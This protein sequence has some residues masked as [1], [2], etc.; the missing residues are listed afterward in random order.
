MT[1]KDS[2]TIV[3]DNFRITRGYDV[4]E[5]KNFK[6][7]KQDKGHDKCIASFINAIKDGKPSPIPFKDLYHSSLISIELAESIEN[8]LFN[9]E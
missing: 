9:S 2:S 1:F 4:S 3:L 6:T 7:F 8:T 5:M